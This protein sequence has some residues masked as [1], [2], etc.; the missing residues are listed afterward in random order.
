MISRIIKGQEE[1][2]RKAERILKLRFSDS[3][4]AA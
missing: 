1:V 3:P 2:R 4:D